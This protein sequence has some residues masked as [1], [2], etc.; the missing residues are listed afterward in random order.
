MKI[1]VYQ[2]NNRDYV[3]TS[4]WSYDSQTICLVNKLLT[5]N[6][7]DAKFLIEIFPFVSLKS[8]YIRVYGLTQGVQL[9]YCIWHVSCIN[10][11]S[12]QHGDIEFKKK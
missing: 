9:R 1:T 12:K 4:R 3:T 7:F 6:I 10:I 5:K 8:H 11:L 2:Y